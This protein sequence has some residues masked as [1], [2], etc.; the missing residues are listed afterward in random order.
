[1]SAFEAAVESVSRSTFVGR[2]GELG[3]LDAA[4]RR[5]ADGRPGMVVVAGEAG[6]GKSRLIEEFAE[7]AGQA[8]AVV[9]VGGAAP[10]AGGA[11]PY[12]PLV[13]MLRALAEDRRATSSEA[14]RVELSRVLAWLTTD[15]PDGRG[16][17]A[18][19]VGRGRLFDLL[20][21]LLGR[22][23]RAAP[24][25][26]VL[27][28]LHWA[29]SA[30]LDFLAYLL[31]GLRRARLLVVGSY[32]VDEPGE[33]LAGWL[34]EVRRLR[35]VGWVELARFSRAELAALLVGLRGGPVDGA[36]VAEVFDRSEGNPFFAE[37]L[38]A[39]GTGAGQVRLPRS[40]R[41]VLLARVHHLSPAGQH[42]LAAAA[43]AGRRQVCPHRLLAAVAGGAEE[44]LTDR[45][46]EALDHGLLVVA[47]PGEGGPDR[48]VFR[49]A[50]LQ[51]AVYGEL[52][53]GQRAR[54]HEGYARAL[55]GPAADRPA[56][57][58]ELAAEV[59][60]HLTIFSRAASAHPAGR[61]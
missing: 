47:P 2:T 19:E 12:A 21:G 30:T 23:G 4:L 59:A 36:V 44:E 18:P 25:L 6:V 14:E 26:L 48:Y 57:V 32:R 28:D 3:R 35:A 50:L 34:A 43:V 15:S 29:D 58:P 16:T 22:L 31:R 20:A 24:L 61:L 10:L 5:A 60:E 8:G 52:L 55:A 42:L 17:C 40:L 33:R 53:A 54:L 51:E 38:F 41:E 9:A 39:A 56:R 1:M 37:E 49:H 13:Q 11:L 45:L 46:R 27:E 7:R